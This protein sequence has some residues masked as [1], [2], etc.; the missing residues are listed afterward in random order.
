MNLKKLKNIPLF[1]D[2]PGDVLKAVAPLI[3]EEHYK[4]DEIIF[5]EGSS[6]DKFFIIEEG[7]VDIRKV[8]NRKDNRFKLIAVLVNG[9]FF[10]EM[11]IFLGGKR[12]AEAVA[13]TDVT[14]A[15]V[16]KKDLSALFG[17]SPK[18]AFKI[19]EFFSSVIMDRLK[20]TTTELVTVYEAGRLISAAK[21]IR[22]ISECVM[23]NVANSIKPEA[24][25]FA[26]WNKFNRDFEIH[27]SRKFNLEKFASFEI[28]EPLVTWFMENREP[29][30]SFDLK[31]DK[32]ILLTKDSI[33][34]G[35][36]MLAAPFFSQDVLLGFALFLDRKKK[37]AFSYEDMII[38]SAISGYVAVALD[39]LQYMQEAIDRARLTQAKSSIPI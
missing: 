12:S 32:R 33:Y 39:N 17:R 20:K 18:A 13:K 19:M 14:V 16:N 35:R 10:G 34:K 30:L 11:A 38:L 23:G 6:A 3:S 25:L 21:S 1:R 36:S 2:I 27:D 29:F 5:V 31:S 28:N 7:E 37:N 24:A 4:E 22:E 9:E 8:I 26:V 15:T